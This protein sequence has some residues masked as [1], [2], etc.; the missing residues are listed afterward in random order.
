[1]VMGEGGSYN[2]E[3]YNKLKFTWKKFFHLL[4]DTRNGLHVCRLHVNSNVRTEDLPKY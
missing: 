1:M 2:S 3:S 4:S